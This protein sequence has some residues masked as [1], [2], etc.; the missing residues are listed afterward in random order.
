MTDYDNTNRGQ[1]W[2][3]DKKETD[4]HPDW[5]GSINV[6]GVEYWLSAWNRKKDANPKAPSVTISIK[7]KEVQPCQPSGGYDNGFTQ[8]DVAQSTG[9]STAPV[10][11]EEDIPFANPY[12]HMEYLL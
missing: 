2:K 5:T 11:F 1:F 4:N 9:R 12:K 6:E 10:D 7:K 3:N 8:P